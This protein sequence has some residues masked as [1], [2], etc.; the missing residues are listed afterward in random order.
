MPIK[1]SF[2]L[3]EKVWD[4][5]RKAVLRRGVRRMSKEVEEALKSYNTLDIL[6][7][8]VES[9]NLERRFPSSEEVVSSRPKGAKA[10]GEV[11][12][13]RDEALP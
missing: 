5:F 7:K 3:N 8:A 12:R 1:T 11:R 10:G 9:L 4:S 6:R 2:Y 13:M